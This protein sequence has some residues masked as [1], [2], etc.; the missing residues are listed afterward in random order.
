[1]IML[2]LHVLLELVEAAVTFRLF[3]QMTTFT[4]ET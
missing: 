4:E 1:M 3:P 2:P